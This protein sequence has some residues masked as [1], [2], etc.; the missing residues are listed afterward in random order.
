MTSLTGASGEDF[1]SILRSLG[2]RMER[3]PKPAEPAQAAAP[4]EQVAVPG[5]ST[6]LPDGNAQIE[7]PSSVDGEAAP[8]GGAP[9]VGHEALQEPVE[10]A[11][12]PAAD[13]VTAIP[14]A[15]TETTAAPAHTAI[16][17]SADI[18]T[19]RPAGE[20]GITE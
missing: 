18:A 4:I 16:E 15:Q 5:E 2:Y 19:H 3:R 14:A 17:T 7:A 10:A 20:T 9:E 13:F 11:L 8:S 12:Q 1:A 6:A